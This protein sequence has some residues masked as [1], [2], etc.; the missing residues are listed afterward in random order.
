[1]SNVLFLFDVDGTLTLPRKTVNEPMVSFLE[2]L[3]EKGS[4]G[5]VGGS[6]LK[7]IVEQLGGDKE[8]LLQSFDF[9]FSE[10]GLVAYKDGKF[11]AEQSI[12]E[13]IGDEVLQVCNVY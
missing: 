4:V 6:D 7:K 10:N 9:V 11:L 1:M 12:Q 13:H 5:V 8:K 3:R 2:K